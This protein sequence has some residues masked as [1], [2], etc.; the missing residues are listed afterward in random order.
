M[1]IPRGQQIAELL[2]RLPHPDQCLLTGREWLQHKQMRDG[3]VGCDAVE[4]CSDSI[5]D[6]L[7]AVDAFLRRSR[8]RVDC[9]LACRVVRS[10]KTGFFPLEQLVKGRSGYLCAFN[11][12]AHG[13]RRI[14]LLERQLRDRRLEANSLVD[15]DVLRI[16]TRSRAQPPR[17]RAVTLDQGSHFLPIPRRI[18]ASLRSPSTEY[19]RKCN[20]RR[21]RA[22]RSSSQGKSTNDLPLRSWLLTMVCGDQA[23]MVPKSAWAPRRSSIGRSLRHITVARAASLLF[24]S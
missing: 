19:S 7:R 5:F 21:P 10:Q 2:F 13:D 3:Y 8:H 12:L 17:V 24:Q 6:Q 11:Q 1:F 16:L 4:E 18:R 23:G 20:S 9:D 15:G 14:P 22:S